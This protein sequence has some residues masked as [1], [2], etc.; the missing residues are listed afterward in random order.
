METLC[1]EQQRSADT[2]LL[3]VPFPEFPGIDI[4]VKDETIHPTG[5]L[6]HRLAR[7]PY[8][9]GLANGDIVEGTHVVEASS[10]STAIAEAY[11]AEL[12]GLPFTAVIPACTAK[13]KVDAI[14]NAGGAVLLA[15]AGEDLCAVAAGLA[16]PPGAHFM[17]Q[18][19]FAERATDWRG[20]NNIAESIFDQCGWSG[21]PFQSGWWLAMGRAVLAPPLAALC[22][23]G[24]GS[25]ERGS[26]SWIR[27]ALRFII[28]TSVAAATQLA[29]IAT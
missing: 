24:Q 16:E 12:L 11:F 18:F 14:R 9:H 20:N 19:T 28:A 1:A 6:K 3:H 29:P 23:T 7:S 27:K 4:Y 15:A 2:H 21:M 17:D 22:A 5:S 8:L 26:A 25:R 10:G 13:A